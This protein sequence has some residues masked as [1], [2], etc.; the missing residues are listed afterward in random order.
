M[1][2]GSLVQCAKEDSNLHGILLPPAPQAGASANSAT[3][4]QRGTDGQDNSQTGNCGPTVCG[5]GAWLAGQPVARL[6]LVIG[7][8]DPL[9][10]C[11][12]VLLGE[13]GDQRAWK[14]A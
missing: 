10:F 9:Y 8:H 3:R 1:V 5:E 2:P 13:M 6:G 4:A 11:R 12:N 7:Q 14:Q